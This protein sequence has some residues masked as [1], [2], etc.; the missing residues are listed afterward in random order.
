MAPAT[1]YRSRMD[2][3]P[4][5]TDQEMED[6]VRQINRYTV[7]LLT[8][9]RGS[10]KIIGTGFLR[11][12]RS[13]HY[14]VT[15]DSLSITELT[16]RFLPRQGIPF[17]AVGFPSSQASANSATRTVQSTLVS[18]GARSCS[19]SV[20]RK[21]RLS[22][23]TNNVLPYERKW[24]DGG[25]MRRA[26]TVPHPVGRSGGPLCQAIGGARR[27]SARAGRTAAACLGAGA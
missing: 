17:L 3:G 7:A 21:L 2:H 12:V 20:Y 6:L 23:E 14:L 5:P 1:Y 25:T 9:D 22:P 15:R 8:M 27:P 19:P 18:Y 4:P 26:Q 24:S 13:R 10:Y 11:R 16:P